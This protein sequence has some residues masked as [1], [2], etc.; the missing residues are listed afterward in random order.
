[1]TA[2]RAAGRELWTSE[3]SYHL[4]EQRIVGGADAELGFEQRNRCSLELTESMV[5]TQDME[6]AVLGTQCK[7][8]CF[9]LRPT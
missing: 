2:R 8:R 6:R 4:A 3:P 5:F 9:P 1:M 7:L